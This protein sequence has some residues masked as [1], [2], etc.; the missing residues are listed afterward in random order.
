MG[1]NENLLYLAGYVDGDGHFK[2]RK[3]LQEGY[4]CFHCK[5]MITSTNSAPLQHFKEIFGG[6]FYLK[7]HVNKH[8]KP[9]FIYTLHVGKK[10]YESIKPLGNLLVEKRDQFLLIEPF[11]EADKTGKVSC[12]EQATQMRSS[13]KV[14]K[15]QIEQ[16][17]AI[18]LS[19]PIIP[20]EY[21]YLAGFIDAECSLTITRKILQPTQSVSYSCHLRC[22]ST[23]YPNIEY[24]IKKLGGC[25]SFT[26][27]KK[28]NASDS[29]AWQLADKSL[30]KHLPFL[31]PY[32]INKREQCQIIINLR[33]TYKNSPA[34]R[35]VNFP[36]FH[37]KVTPLRQRYYSDIQALNKRGL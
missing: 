17:K 23:K 2:F 33:E 24:L 27:T 35:S 13:N 32:L 15:E 16:L 12:I 21:P 7:R 26:K 19:E 4:E 6:T 3:Y 9:E 34:I 22:S 11:F 30:E 36:D 14:H 18:S 37:S 10:T 31:L 8:W 5:L 29:V 20:C 1:S 25:V 28:V